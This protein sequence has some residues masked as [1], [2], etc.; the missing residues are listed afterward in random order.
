M[1]SET[2]KALSLMESPSHTQTELRRRERRDERD[3]FV[4]D[5]AMHEDSMENGQRFAAPPSRR[6]G[7]GLATALRRYPVL[8]LLPVVVLAA[9]GIT[10]GLRR[11]PTYTAS[12]TINVGAPDINSQATPGYAEAEQ[13]LASAYSREVTS[14]YIYKPVASQMHLSQ[15]QVASRV[16]SSA[17]PSSPTFTINA[18]GPTQQSAIALAGAATSALQHYINVINQGENASTSLLNRYRQAEHQADYLSAVSGRLSGQNTVNPASVSPTRL[19]NAKVAAQVA[20]LQANALANQYT[21]SS[22]MSRG[23]IIQVLNPA[24]SATSDRHSIAER[25]GIVGTA[26]GAILGAALA[27]LVANLRRRRWPADALA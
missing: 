23:A 21:N 10:L 22:T 14:Q 18:T 6:R 4:L 19:R 1:N 15:T 2:G 13:T 3:E 9:A 12:S 17:V 5:R 25:Y 26:A 7:V 8:A 11:P 27:L 16:S 24:S 20:Q